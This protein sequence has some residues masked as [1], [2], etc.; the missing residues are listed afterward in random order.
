MKGLKFIHTADWHLGKLVHGLYMTEDQRFVLQQFIEL[1][2]QEKPDAVIIAGDLYDRSVPP[3]EAVELLEETL[4]TI[5]FELQ[6]PVIAVSGNHDS[7]ERL[8]FGASWYKKHQLHINGKIDNCFTP[9]QIQD[10]DFYLVPYFEPGVV[11]HYFEDASIRSHDDAMKKITA[12]IEKNMNKDRLN[13]FVGHAFVIGG[14]TSDS[15][16]SLSVGGT[17]AVHSSYFD[18]FD[19][20]ALGHL[21]SPHALKHNKV[22]Y[23]GSILKYS[24]SEVNHEKSVRIVEFTENGDLTIEERFLTP[25]KDMKELK[26]YLQE[27]IDP[28]FYEQQKLDDYYKITL[29]DEGAII[30][31]IGKLRLVYPNVLHLER[32]IEQVNVG[33]KQNYV[34]T[35]HTKKTEL[36]LYEEF[37]E[38]MTT[39]T[40]DDKKREIMKKTIEYVKR[41]LETK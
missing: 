7:A 5:N 40:F 27:L 11:S 19:Y 10:V 24:F 33:E 6:T 26:G 14:E 16:R 32:K 8:S 35:D 38:Q 1:V 21:H 13:I 3:T 22:I 28:A 25:D 15:E 9:V 31:P 18:A 20:T 36:D 29:L 17:G 30:D 34:L 39:S 41:E 4:M 23:A 2:K 12:E 37:Y